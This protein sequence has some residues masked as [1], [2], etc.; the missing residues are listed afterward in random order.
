MKVAI[1][2]TVVVMKIIIYWYT[3]VWNEDWTLP[4]VIVLHK[5]PGTL[6]CT[7]C[8]SAILVTTH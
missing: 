1:E 7:N 3:R 4:E 5:A 6:D 2:T 8:R